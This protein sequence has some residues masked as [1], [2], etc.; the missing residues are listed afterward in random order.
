MSVHALS[1]TATPFISSALASQTR[2]INLACSLKQQVA[3][4]SHFFD[5]KEFHTRAAADLHRSLFT[6]RS[7]VVPSSP[8][9]AMEKGRSFLSMLGFGARGSSAAQTDSPTA[10]IAHGP[11]DDAPAPG[12]QFAAF[13]AGCFWGVELA[14]QRVPGVTKTEVGYSQ[15]N[16]HKPSYNDVCSGTTGMNVLPVIELSVFASQDMCVSLSLCLFI[17]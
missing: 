4:V 10:G 15:G 5:C 16:T 8:A 9:R 14:Y 11:D 6:T 1:L 13:G 12:Q 17:S 3:L 2:R 7:F